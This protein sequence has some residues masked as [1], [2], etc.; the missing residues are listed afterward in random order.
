MVWVLVFI[1][2]I[3]NRFVQERNQTQAHRDRGCAMHCAL[4]IVLLAYSPNAL[5]NEFRF[6]FN[7]CLS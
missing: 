4:C 5:D 6:F 1:I 7:I 2:I 3:K